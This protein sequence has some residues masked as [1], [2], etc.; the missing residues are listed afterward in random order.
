MTNNYCD[1][2]AAAIPDNDPQGGV[3]CTIPVAEEST[4]SAIQVYVD[5]SHTYVADMVVSLISPEGT[6]VILHNNQG[7]DGDNVVGWYSGELTPFQSL[8]TLLGESITGDWQLH[9]TDIGPYDVGT[10]NSWCVMLTYEE[11][12]SLSGVD[13]ENLPQVLALNG[14]HPNPFNPMT[15]I[16]FSVPAAQCVE[17]A[18]YDVRG[19]RVRTLVREVMSAGHHTV[20]WMGRD[21]SGRGV[22]S[23]AY[24]YRLSSGGKS[25]V[26]KMMLMK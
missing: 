26:G 9:V 2:P 10:I 25:V 21:D 3:Y 16:K 20:N 23:G 12:N 24:F 14:N 18:V 11:H 19:V 5:I 17:L 6:T 1:D 7:G 13:D 4:V 22:A 8:D 15:A